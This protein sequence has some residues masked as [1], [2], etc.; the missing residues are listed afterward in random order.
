MNSFLVSQYSFGRFVP[1][2]LT[3]VVVLFLFFVRRRRKGRDVYLILYF[4]FLSIFHVSYFLVFS[5]YSVNAVFL[6]WLVALAPLGLTFLM[7]FAYRFPSH[8]LKKESKG[9]LYL[10]LLLSVVSWFEF[11]NKTAFQENIR[12]SI[13]DYE[14]ANG[15]ELIPLLCLFQLLWTVIVFL[16]QSLAENTAHRNENVIARIITPPDALSRAA[17]D[18]AMVTVLE[19]VNAVAVVLF[20]SFNAMSVS[21]VNIIMNTMFM[22]T[23]TLY[24]VVYINTSDEPMMLSRRFTGIILVTVLSVLQIMGQIALGVSDRGWDERNLALLH[25]GKDIQDLERIHE[26]RYLLHDGKTIF[27]RDEG[28]LRILKDVPYKGMMAG[29]EKNDDTEGETVL[30]TCLFSE[31][32]H[33]CNYRFTKEGDTFNVGFSFLEYRRYIHSTGML[34][35]LVTLASTLLVLLLSPL[36]LSGG[37]TGPLR[38]LIDE[39]K[40]SL[41]Q[42]PDIDDEIRLLVDATTRT[43]RM[44]RAMKSELQRLRNELVSNHAAKKSSDKLSPA[45]E[46]KMLRVMDYIEKNYRFD[47]SRE[48][49]AAYFDMS[50]SFLS[51]TF[52]GYSGMKIAEYINRLRIHDA[53]VQLENSSKTVTEIAFSVGFESLRTFNRA[54][55]RIAGKTP[56]AYR[57]TL[58]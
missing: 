51:R 34:L 22:A 10:S 26:I 55:S 12:F 20:M 47:I 28:E 32:N 1:A 21:M 48:G 29:L 4:F 27:S 57:D 24:V 7:Q 23:M 43:L 3:V 30:R 8:R 36:L 46:E 31:W 18:F 53:M 45:L 11:F 6:W 56:S 44:N 58:R 33:Y 54:F 50:V 16:R 52:N 38:R 25:H 41:H 42:S 49:L 35:V 39:L 40:D 17:R 13:A 5:I 19:I 9:V 37:I 15:S 14:F 2:L